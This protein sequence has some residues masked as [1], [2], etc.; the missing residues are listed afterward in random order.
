MIVKRCAWHS[1]YVGYRMVYGIAS[2]RGA[3]LVFADGM[4]RGC[5]RRWRVESTGDHAFSSPDPV[6]PGWMPKAGLA[7]AVL[8]AIVLAARPIDHAA[9]VVTGADGESRAS[10]RIARAAP[11][12]AA[13]ATATAPPTASAAPPTVS[14]PASASAVLPTVSGPVSASAPPPT[15]SGATAT[16]SAA[17]AASAAPATASGGRLPP[18]AARGVER[19]S[20]SSDAPRFDRRIPDSTS[21]LAAVSDAEDRG[22]D[23]AIR[24]SPAASRNGRP[25]VHLSPTRS[26]SRPA[27]GTAPVFVP[28]SLLDAERRSTWSSAAPCRHVPARAATSSGGAAVSHAG[29]AVAPAPCGASAPSASPAVVALTVQAP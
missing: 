16:A 11:I 17:A 23:R 27:R 7:V 18:G 8:V 13:T 20:G 3:R 29:T 25:V 12:T 2:W 24:R 15:V 28:A 14:G 6:I 5:A 1:R 10:A 22:G 21:R 9:R 4:C 26:R 19:V